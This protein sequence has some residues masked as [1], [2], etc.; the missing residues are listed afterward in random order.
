MKWGSE[1]RELKKVRYDYIDL[2][3]IIAIIMVI[4]L[5]TIQF[6]FDFITTNNIKR[7]ISFLIRIICE[8]VPIF[9]CINGFLI[10][11]KDFDL[12]KHLKKTL[13]IFV[14][15]IIWC[16]VDIISI[17]LIKHENINIKAI[18]NNVLLTDITNKYTGPLWFL[19][20]LIM[21]YLIFP[22]LKI[23]HDNCKKIYNYLFI[24]VAFF[25]VGMNFLL[26]VITIL[27]NITN[28]DIKNFYVFLERYNPI[29]NGS[30][31][32]FFMLGGYIFENKG[33]LQIKKY[34]VIPISIGILSILSAFGMGV[35][36]SKTS[37][38][39]VSGGFNY[40]TI[41]M[42]GIII[43]LFSIFCNYEN[44]NYIHNKLIM[45]LGKNSLGIYLVHKVII[46]IM[47]EYLITEGIIIG[48]IFQPFIV[49]IFS[50]IIV[51]IIKKIPML[52]KIV[53]L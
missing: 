23:V 24:V 29:S 48:K 52:H 10:I 20:N 49:L 21:L 6:N 7:Y 15:M 47:N 27:Q 35:I 38:K 14:I 19:Q 31:I 32:F 12:N 42:M 8:G 1:V 46:A 28:F 3:K 11:N 17:K 9:V 43:A 5:H 45:D 34:R 40:S 13:R 51:K 33:I 2:L 25:T 41:F 30:F 37:G 39:V 22:V 50:Y 18:V 53:E 16:I 26:N 44:K 4:I 36:I